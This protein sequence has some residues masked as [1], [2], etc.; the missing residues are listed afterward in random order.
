MLIA[1][2]SLMVAKTDAKLPECLFAT[3]CGEKI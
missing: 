1:F 2:V 3:K